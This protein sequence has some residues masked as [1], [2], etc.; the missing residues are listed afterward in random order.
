MKACLSSAAHDRRVDATMTNGSRAFPASFVALL[1]PSRATWNFHRAPWLYRYRHA[2]RSRL[3]QRKSVKCFW[4]PG[5]LWVTACIGY[6]VR[7]SD[8]VV[9][10]SYT[11]LSS[12]KYSGPKIQ[13]LRVVLFDQCFMYGEKADDTA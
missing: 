6:S 3:R 11:I 8:K 10:I 5:L 12:M 13:A 4:E 1:L 2:P 7:N 9:G